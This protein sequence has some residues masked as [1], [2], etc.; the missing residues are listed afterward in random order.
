KKMVG[1]NHGQIV[2]GVL[3]LHR[4]SL[5]AGKI[6]DD[7]VEQQVP[8]GYP[9]KTPA[10]VQ[11]KCARLELV[12]VLRGLGSQLSGFYQF[13]EFCVHSGSTSYDEPLFSREKTRCPPVICNCGVAPT[14]KV[15]AGC[16]DKYL[17]LGC[18][19]CRCLYRADPRPGSVQA[20]WT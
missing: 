8:V 13:G 10:L 19:P 6:D 17:V 15:F 20:S 11:T 14:M 9:A 16:A 18:I 5:F 7:L 1:G 3:E 2:C 4:M 12:Q